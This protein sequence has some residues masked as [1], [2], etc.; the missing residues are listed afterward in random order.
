VH[1]NDN[2][3]IQLRH[4]AATIDNGTTDRAICPF[5]DGGSTHERCFAVT[6]TSE[7]EAKYCCHRATCGRHGRL[8]VW[9]FKLEQTSF[10]DQRT[11]GSL[12]D[13]STEKRKSFT[14]RLYSRD[15]GELGDEWASELLDLYGI[16]PLEAHGEGWRVE[17]GSGNLVVPVR[18]SLGVVRGVEVRRSKVQVPYVSSPKTVTYRFLDEPWLGWYRGIK[19]GPTILVE[20]AISALKVS[21]HFQVVCLHGS[22]IAIEMLLEMVGVVGN[23]EIILALDNDA[24]SKALEFVTK[25]RFI[26]PNFR[27]V[28][29]IKDLKYVSDEEICKLM[30]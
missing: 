28:P 18:S 22:H 8:A 24:T 19:S 6:R 21:R 10:G 13:N 26:A 14:P 23:S 16:R 20:D 25:W 17:I 5:C 12:L 30:K 4:F 2:S 15:T 27:A 7:A 11:E 29:L 1:S 3:F 9:G